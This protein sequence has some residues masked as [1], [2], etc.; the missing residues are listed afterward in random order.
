[1]ESSTKAQTMGNENMSRWTVLQRQ[2]LGYEEIVIVQ[3]ELCG[4]A[5]A[6]LFVH[7]LPSVQIG[8]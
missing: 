8:H 4:A 3:R 5:E 7:L 2:L 6:Q 1:M